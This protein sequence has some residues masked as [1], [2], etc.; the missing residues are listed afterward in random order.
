MHFGSEAGQ[1]ATT[2]GGLDMQGSV[3][4]YRS[5]GGKGVPLAAASAVPQAV[6]PTSAANIKPKMRYTDTIARKEPTVA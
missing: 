5:H 4:Q 6:M 2:I 3:S 1:D